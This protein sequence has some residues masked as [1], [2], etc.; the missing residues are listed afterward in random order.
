MGAHPIAARPAIIGLVTHHLPHPARWRA[1]FIA[2]T[3]AL[4]AVAARADETP[5]VTP[6]RPSVSTPAT[7]SAPG[8]LE[9]EAGAQRS[10]AD[11]P[12]RRDT[13]PYSLK[14][15]FTPDWGIRIGGDALVRELS[16]DGASL[17]GGGDTSV[18]LKRRFAVDDASAFGIELGAKFPTARDGLGSGHAD[19]GVNGIYSADFA[20]SWHVDF[21]ASATH[22][23]GAAAGT[24][25]WQAGWAAALSRTLSDQW[26]AVGELSGTQRS[27]TERTRQA[28]VAASYAPSRAVTFDAGVS[29]G[30]STASGGWSVF[31]GVTFL[32]AR[33]F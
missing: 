13:L 9:V 25:A 31:T 29:K 30:L 33:L 15:A 23:G 28:L 19:L 16:A 12:R 10:W 8:W 1:L 26:S 18:V 14:L 21:N 11:E 32:A 2:S 4:S 6:Y 20:G 27:G 24:S 17:R 22:L 5:A 7:L 3:L